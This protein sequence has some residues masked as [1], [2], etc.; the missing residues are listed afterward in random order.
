VSGRLGQCQLGQCQL[1]Q[2]A[3]SRER[4]ARPTPASCTQPAA[5][6]RLG[7]RD[8]L[9]S[10]VSSEAQPRS[11][12]P[13]R[14]PRPWAA[15][16]DRHRGPAIMGGLRA[17]TTT[18]TAGRR[19]R[20]DGERMANGWRAD[21]ERM[22]NGWRTDG[23]QDE[24][25]WFSRPPFQRGDEHHHQEERSASA[26]SH[27]RSHAR[28]CCDLVAI[29]LRSRVLVARCGVRLSQR[30]ASFWPHA[31]QQQERSQHWAAC[32][33]CVALGRHF[34][35]TLGDQCEEQGQVRCSA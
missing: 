25:A 29:S 15:G 8:D 20:A 2:A 19:W 18:T 32:C 4:E 22:A 21:G 23:E 13:P 9:Q 28:S 35:S 5:P 14:R 16:R 31:R 17:A 12:P 26:R 1:G 30:R 7:Q 34:G 27:T 3:C 33:L 10:A 11:P 24:H 6:A